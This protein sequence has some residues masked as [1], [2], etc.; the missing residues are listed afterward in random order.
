M[1]L[2]TGC[3][4]FI[5][6]HLSKYLLDTD[7]LVIGI[8]NLNDYYSQQLKHDR[9]AIL[10][11]YKKFL[12]YFEDITDKDSLRDIIHREYPKVIVHLAGQA[13][14]E[15]SF[16]RP[17]S[18]VTNNI[19]GTTNLLEIIKFGS[20]EHFILASSSS[21][22]GMSD[23]IPYHESINVNNP[24]SIYAA[25]KISCEQI[26]SI[27]AREYVIP[28]TVLRF[29]SVYGPFGRP[30]MIVYLFMESMRKSRNIVLFNEG[31]DIRSFTYINDLVKIIDKI[32]PLPPKNDERY[33]I[34]NAGNIESH[35]VSVLLNT[36]ERIT[37]TTA[38]KGIGG[39][40]SIDISKSIPDISELEKL[41]GKITFTKLEDGLQECYNWY[42]DYKNDMS[43]V[44]W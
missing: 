14:V 13:G 37:E 33:R 2:V 25:S 38:L 4:G 24:M 42:K 19:L 28:T 39:K 20:F 27:Y 9:L 5:G 26:A 44:G 16:T 36:L 29:F 11:D 6:F 10:K 43:Y 32:I 30:D 40:R 22:Y 12:F 8:D 34:L 18:Y 35:S 41:I 23:K 31:K 17:E 1:I 21:V 15:A 3:C 7:R